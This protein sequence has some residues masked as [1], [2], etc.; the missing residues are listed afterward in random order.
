M[1]LS[2]FKFIW[3]MEWCHRQWGRLI[4]VAYA[5]P[6]ALFWY[7]GYFNKGM[8]IRVASYGALIGFQVNKSMLHIW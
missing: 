3:Y 2:R 6:A 8:K 1:T 4:G 7:K 5:I